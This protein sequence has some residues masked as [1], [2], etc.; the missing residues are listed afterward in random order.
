MR[1]PYYESFII[2]SAIFSY[3]LVVMR[4]FNVPALWT[5]CS[6]VVFALVPIYPGYITSVVKDAP[7]AY[8]VVLFVLLFVQCI[9]M[10]RSNLRLVGLFISGIL[11]CLAS[12]TY[13]NNGVRYAL[14][15]I[16]TNMFMIGMC[17]RCSSDSGNCCII[18]K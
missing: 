6:L 18:E 3:C 11:V 2:G 4:R 12:P 16:Y 7:F 8:M 14:P 13:L 9:Y 1:C 10:D 17:I 5:C 15:V